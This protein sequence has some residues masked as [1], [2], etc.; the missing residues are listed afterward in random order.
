VLSVLWAKSPDR[1]NWTS[2]FVYRIAVTGAVPV[3]I[4]LASLFPEVGGSLVGLLEPIQ[5]ALP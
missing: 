4:I 1:I 2:G 5:K 3:A